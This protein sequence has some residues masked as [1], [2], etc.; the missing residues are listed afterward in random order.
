MKEEEEEK[1]EEGEQEGKMI[2]MM[3]KVLFELIVKLHL[4]I[5]G[6]PTE[7]ASYNHM[8]NSSFIHRSFYLQ[9]LLHG[10]TADNFTGLQCP[11]TIKFP[12]F[13]QQTK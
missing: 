7:T 5:L 12:M 3:K 4:N 11:F 1:E 2:L 10:A 8:H 6:L 9:Y 13:F